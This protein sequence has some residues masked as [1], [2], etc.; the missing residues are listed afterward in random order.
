MA[1]HVFALHFAVPLIN[2]MS[3]QWCGISTNKKKGRNANDN[4]Y[5]N[6]DNDGNN[7]NDDDDNVSGCTNNNI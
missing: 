1:K 5:S 2:E 4:G 7:I 3:L 6:I